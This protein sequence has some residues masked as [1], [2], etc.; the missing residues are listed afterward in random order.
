MDRM[1]ETLKQLAIADID[2]EFRCIFNVPKNINQLSLVI[3]WQYYLVH[4]EYGS[5]SLCM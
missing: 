2:C 5:Y 4:S 1:Q 3:H